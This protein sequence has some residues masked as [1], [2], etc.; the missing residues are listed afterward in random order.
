MTTP[1]AFGLQRAPTE[2][3]VHLMKT[4]QIAAPLATHFRPASCAEFQCDAYLNGWQTIVPADSPAAEYIRHDRT[5]RCT[6]ERQPDGLT[7]FTFEPGQ[8]GFAGTEHDHRLPNGRAERYFERGGDW[9]GNP[10]R[11]R[12]ELRAA[13]WVDSFANNMDSVKTQMERG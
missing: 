9:R 6:E 2:F 11:D 1:D 10:R 4:Y 12:R 5:R 7:C 8:Q 3:P 13:D